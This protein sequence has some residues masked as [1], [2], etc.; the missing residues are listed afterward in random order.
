M[1]L[2][3][4]D[5]LA[6]IYSR[7]GSQRAV[8]RAT[9]LSHQQVGRI[10]HNAATGKTNARYES[11][12]WVVGGVDHAI[13]QQ[14]KALR[15]QAKREG[16]PF[17]SEIP[18]YATRLPMKNK[19]VRVNGRDVFKG[20]PED[21]ADLLKGHA[22]KREYVD[23]QGVK[24]TRVDKLTPD[25]IK[26]ATVVSFL[27]DRVG[28]EHMHWV[29]DKLRA[30]WLAKQQKTGKFY[31][32]T[33]G[34]TV[35]LPTYMRTARARIKEYMRQGGLTNLDR[36]RARVQLDK[37]N[38]GFAANQI[39]KENRTAKIYTPQTSLDPGFPASMIAADIKEKLQQRHEPATGMPGTSL[40]SSV[41]LQLD[42]RPAH[43]DKQSQRATPTRSAGKARPRR[44]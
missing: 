9:G 1:K 42:T 16:I 38:R 3:L 12:D 2:S 37:L 39:E 11:T 34:S 28:S 35:N 24:R 13:A 6:V 32:V 10:L 41:I 20:A 29:S 14:A 22:V 5:K 26:G 43:V 27:G 8:A 31:A 15:E 30:A 25:Q 17:S 4:A 23:R 19:A 33:V 36:E 40:A 44:K 18:I 7:E 21:V